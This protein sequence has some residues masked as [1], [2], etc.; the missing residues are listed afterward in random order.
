MNK[1]KKKKNGKRASKYESKDC[2]Q[3]ISVLTEI[4]T[5]TI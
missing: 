4:S 5:G 1:K 2:T 3:W